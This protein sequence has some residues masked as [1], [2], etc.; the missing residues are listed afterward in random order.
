MEKTYHE[1][2]WKPEERRAKFEDICKTISEGTWKTKA[3]EMNGVPASTFWDWL[4][5]YFNSKEDSELYRRACDIMAD[6]MVAKAIDIVDEPIPTT[7][8]GMGLDRGAVEH[9]KL[10]FQARQWVI[11]RTCR[12][13]SEKAHDTEEIKDV[14]IN[15]TFEEAKPNGHQG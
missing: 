4:Y 12:R 9:A 13:Y 11:G 6:N 7:P 14:N 15:I 8:N 2:D 1:D 10:R 5:K 3:C